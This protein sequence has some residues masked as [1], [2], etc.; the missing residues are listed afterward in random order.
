M[1]IFPKF[2]NIALLFTINYISV[3]EAALPY[4]AAWL[5]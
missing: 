4:C 3:V 1:K 2:A 5:K